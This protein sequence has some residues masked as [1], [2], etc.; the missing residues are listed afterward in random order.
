[1]MIIYIMDFTPKWWSRQG[2]NLLPQQCKC[3][4][5][6]DELQPHWVDRWDLNPQHPESQSGV[7]PLNYCQHGSG[8]GS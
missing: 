7:L 1:M 4:A 6:P 3:C 5:L 2:S 8:G